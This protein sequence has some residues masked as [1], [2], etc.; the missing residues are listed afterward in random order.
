MPVFFA[1]LTSRSRARCMSFASVG[2]AAALGCTVGVPTITLEKSAAL[3]APARVDREA[4]L[5][6]RDKLSSPIRWRQRVSDE[7]SKVSL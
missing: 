2:N 5:D 1:G 4:L 7:R 3:A 6:Q